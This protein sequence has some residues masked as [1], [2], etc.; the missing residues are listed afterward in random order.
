M[1]KKIQDCII[2]WQHY[3][4][5]TA[6]DLYGDLIHDSDLMLKTIPTTLYNLKSHLLERILEY[7]F[8]AEN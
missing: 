2:F 4:M 1:K 7:R 3:P 5:G 8:K 6:L